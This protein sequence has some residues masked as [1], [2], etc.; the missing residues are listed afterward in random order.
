MSPTVPPVVSVVIVNLGSRDA[1]HGCLESLRAAATEF[2]LEVIVVDPASDDGAREWLAAA[3]PEVC[4]ASD[5]GPVDFTHG[6]NLGATLATGEFLFLLSPECE[7][8]GPALRRLVGAGRS[9]PDLAA[10]APMLVNGAARVTRSC[11]RFPD[12]W[13]LFCDHSGLAARFPGSP[14]F[15]RHQYGGRPMESLD[16]VDWASG[17]ALLIPRTA[18]LAVGGLDERIFTYWEEVDWCRRAARQGLRVHFQ[19]Q[20]RIV[21][22]ER[23]AS[24]PAPGEAYLH[25]L[26][27]RV[28]YFRKHGGAA[29]AAVAKGILLLSLA[30]QWAASLAGRAGKAGARTYAAGVEAVWAA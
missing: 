27:S 12:S 23:R 3:Y 29:A 15:G 16:R 20:A 7:V 8:S 28:G 22:R 30:L 18:W 26:R 10:V 5:L 4:C 25:A 13:T 11:G 1:L 17:A 9:L 6:V 2:P 19:P 14:W 24:R 21:H